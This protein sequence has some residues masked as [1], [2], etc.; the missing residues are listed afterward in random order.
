M[1]PFRRTCG[2]DPL[3]QGCDRLG[4]DAVQACRYLVGVLVEFRPGTDSRHDDLKSR[5]LRFGMLIDGDSPAVI[6]HAQAAVHVDFDVNSMAMAG[7]CFIDAVID[8]LI[9]E[10][11]QAARRYVADIHARTL[12]NVGRIPEDLHI[13]GAV[14]VRGVRMALIRHFLAD[15]SGLC[16]LGSRN[17]GTI[18]AHDFNILNSAERFMEKDQ[19]QISVAVARRFFLNDTCTKA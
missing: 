14:L 19:R 7:E 11:V 9:D 17:Q 16:L 5:S 13:T 6:V 10:M 18:F 3:A 4:A 12:A 8:Q 15:A 1:W 2:F